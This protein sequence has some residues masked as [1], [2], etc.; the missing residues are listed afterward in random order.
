[1]TMIKP[2]NLCQFIFPLV[3]LFWILL[4]SA[5]C[6]HNDMQGKAF[7]EQT[8]QA[9]STLEKKG[10]LV[11]AVEELKIALVVDPDNSK[12]REELNRM[13]VKRNLEADKHLKAGIAV[14]DSNPQGARKEF[15]AALRI[16][17]DY[18]E[19]VTALRGLQLES[20]EAV[21]QARTKREAKLA[22]T[23]VHAKTEA[24]EEEMDGV[25]YSLD[26]AIPAFESGD[27]NTA[28]H[29]FGKMKA[30]YPND[31]DIKLY[32]DR[33]WYNSG[34]AWFTKKDFHRALTSFAKV[35]KGFERVDE[36]VARCRSALKTPEGGKVKPAQK[37]RR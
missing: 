31:P 24:D 13:T 1:M 30:R 35:P 23:R 36:Y 22:A 6:A 17:S 12:A 5:G 3:G 26:I 4:I 16:R 34:I 15:V 27:Y 29:E 7:S 33:S 18:P 37:K 19:A 20:A 28:I 32:L 8:V 2:I 14:R 25:E 11:K 21:L 10:D 9:S